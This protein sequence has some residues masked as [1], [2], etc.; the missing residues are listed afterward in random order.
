[1][2]NADHVISQRVFQCETSEL[3]PESEVTVTTPE[4]GNIHSFLALEDSLLIDLLIPSY[5]S[6]HHLCNFYKIPSENSLAFQWNTPDYTTYL[7]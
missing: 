7:L 5:D 2:E 4:I 3:S 6:T 1:M